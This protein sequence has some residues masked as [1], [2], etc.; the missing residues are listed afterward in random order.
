MGKVWNPYKKWRPF[1]RLNKVPL[2]S[3]MTFPSI[4]SSNY[5]FLTL[6]Q[7]YFRRKFNEKFDNSNPSLRFTLLHTAT[8]KG[9]FEIILSL[10]T[11]YNKH[12]N[13]NNTEIT[14]T[15]RIFPKGGGPQFSK[16]VPA[17]KY[18]YKLMLK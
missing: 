7:R 9:H 2:T 8:L 3:S 11:Q 17:S 13:D 4:H 6:S 12:N 15:T 14:R 10:D 1:F 5:S 18:A 16:G